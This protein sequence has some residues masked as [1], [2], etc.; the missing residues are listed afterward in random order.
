MKLAGGL[1]GRQLSH[2]HF[3]YALALHA[4]YPEDM[5]APFQLVGH[6]GNAPELV[7]HESAQ[8]L[9][10]RSFFI[11]KLIDLDDLFKLINRQPPVKQPCSIRAL[12]CS[13]VRL[14]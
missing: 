1:L 6:L 14:G 3:A 10:M 8:C 12:D 2:S 5:T 4:Y 13:Q 11:G 9:E 7:H